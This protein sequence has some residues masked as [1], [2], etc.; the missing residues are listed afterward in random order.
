MA[1]PGTDHVSRSNQG[2]WLILRPTGDGSWEP[3]GR[4]ECWR[5]RG[6]AGASDNLGY[7]FNLLPGVDHAI[8]LAESSISASKGGKFSID[9]TSMQPLS[10]GGMPGCSP[11]DSGDFSQ[12]PLASYSYRGFVMSSSVQGE[13]WCSKPTVEVGLPHIVCAED[14]AAFIALAAVV[15]LSMD[16]CK[17]FSHKLRKELSHLRSNVLR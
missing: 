10:R 15:D 9:L 4:L 14:A 12:W 7:R 16:A 3:W 5:E 1:S 11:R 13:G 2:A 8:P 17:L 6:G